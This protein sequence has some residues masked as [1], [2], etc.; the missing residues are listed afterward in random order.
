MYSRVHRPA[1]KCSA[2][3]SS[4]SLSTKVIPKSAYMP[5]GS[6]KKGEDLVMNGTGKTEKCTVC[7][8]IDLRGLG[9]VP[10]IAGLAPSYT[11]RQLYDMQHSNRTG[12]WSPLMVLAIADLDADDL[13]NAAAYLASLEP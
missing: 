12:V 5:P 4:K 3:A 13:M 11:V 7:H 2:I 9:P 10:R 1:S 6:I 8:G